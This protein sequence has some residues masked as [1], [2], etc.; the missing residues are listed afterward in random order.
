MNCPYCGRE[1]SEML[2]ACEWCH[3]ALP[4]AA[5][6]AQQVR[7]AQSAA[8]PGT[9]VPQPGP[10]QVMPPQP[11]VYPQGPYYPPGAG[12]PLPPRRERGRHPV[13]TW[14]KIA[15]VS[16]VAVLA[17]FFVVYMIVGW[18]SSKE[19]KAHPELVVSDKPTVVEFY[20]S[21]S[22]AADPQMLVIADQLAKE[23]AGRVAFTRIF[24]TV[25]PD[26]MKLYNLDTTPSFVGLSSK[27]ALI[28]T[29]VGLQSEQTMRAF[30][31]KAANSASGGQP[32]KKD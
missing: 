27:G 23:Y 3:G 28:E 15:V 26:T 19:I 29:V 10:A 21:S 14:M 6:L 16:L 8:P 20:S 1:T 13:W 18:G 17:F 4:G 11:P 31:D 2:K 24:T 22:G 12:Y 32:V 30:F 5:T 7:P 25:D 9:Q